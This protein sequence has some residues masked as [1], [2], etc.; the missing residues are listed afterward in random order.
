MP[1]L[2]SVVI[3]S[4]NHASYIEEA[5]RSVLTQPVTDLELV[6]IDDG[7]Q[8]DSVA[9]VGTIDD[10][11]IRLITQDNQGAHAAI[12]RGLLEAR[13]QYLAILNSDDRFAPGRLPAA[14]DILTRSPDVALVG[15]YI[16]VIDGAGQRLAIKAGYANL[17]PWPVPVPE[18]TFKADNDL[19]TALLLQNYWSTTSNYVFPRHIYERYG[20]F[21][22]LR[23]VHD[24]D[25]AL[26][27]QLEQT[28]RLIPQPLLHYRV[29]NSNTIRENRAAMIYEICWVLATH[30]PLYLKQ[31]W[32]WQPG[33][34]QRAQQLQRSIYVYGCD[35]V[36]WGMLAHIHFGPPD[37]QLQLLQPDNASRQFYL[38]E[39]RRTIMPSQPS[40]ADSLAAPRVPQ[41][42]RQAFRS[43]VRSWLRRLGV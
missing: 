5:V 36:L 38:D 22:P 32:F 16:E 23:Y 41:A 33:S 37:S 42:A 11:R 26:R 4:F 25:F 7:S 31:D 9:I 8:D 10:P 29:H 40:A 24:W 43:Q 15:S 6:I 20:P 30:L 14:L 21:R 17:D 34:E 13:G 3:P 12:N 2:I 19:R 28:A 27:V 18:A 1:P 39:I 35:A